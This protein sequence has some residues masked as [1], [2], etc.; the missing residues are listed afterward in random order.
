MRISELVSG[1]EIEFTRDVSIDGIKTDTRK[2]EGADLFV[3]LS[4]HDADG[5]QYLAEAAEAGAAAVLIDKDKKNFLPDNFPL[6]VLT[7]SPP[8][9]LIVPLLQKFYGNPSQDLTLL[10][11]T[12]TN[13]KTTTTHILEAILQAQGE[14]TGLIGTIACRFNG[15][16]DKS[17]ETTTPSVAEN[18]RRL[19]EWANRGGTAVVMEVSSHGLVQGRVEGL[20]FAAA[21]FTNLSRDHLDYHENMEDYYRAKKILFDQSK[22]KVASVGDEYGRRLVKE[23]GAVGVGLEGNYRVSDRESS[24]GGVRLRLETPAGD[25]LNLNSNLTGTFNYENIALAAAIALELEVDP[26][27]VEAGVKNCKN[28]PGRCERI[29]DSPGVIVDYAHTSSAM[30]NVIKSLKPL[31]E[32]EI[33]CVFGAGG[34]RDRGKRPKMGAVADEFADYSI[35]TSDNPRSEDPEQII[36]EI[37]SGMQ[38]NNHHVEVDRGQAIRGALE[39]ATPEDLVLIVG[40]GHETQQVIGDRVIDFNDA[41][42]AR[43]VLQTL[44]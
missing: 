34:D 30:E 24:L 42:V 29:S 4:G 33:I 11:V 38:N 19:S 2:I 27:I 21:G 28:I 35:V 26:E 12:G 6:P 20:S 5:H 44:G 25:I 3:A 37:V 13:G 43:E 1:L 22:I 39:R 36:E 10:G 31:V 15:E 14:S 18:Y 40:K 41:G 8:E 7:A 16:V 9:A 23:E 17:V 32:G